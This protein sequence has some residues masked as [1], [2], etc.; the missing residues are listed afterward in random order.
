LAA[1]SKRKKKEKGPEAEAPVAPGGFAFW[2]RRLR[3]LALGTLVLAA[4]VWLSLPAVGRFLVVADKPAPAEVLVV[5]SGDRGERLE[6]AFRLYQEGLADRLLLSGG[7]L[8]ADLTEADLLRRHALMLGVPEYKIIMEPRA[9]NTY[10]NA[11]YSR[12]MMEYYGL[13]SAIVISSP[14]HM[15][16]VRALF[17]EVY[18]GSDIRLVYLP[19]EDSWFDPER[20]WESAA[21]RRVVL[22][23]YLRLT[24]L[25]LPEQW[26]AFLYRRGT[27]EPPMPERAGRDQPSLKERLDIS[28]HLRPPNLVV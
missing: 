18:R 26:R 16:R 27:G 20:W 23:E 3:N 8:Y 12:E 7:P 28:G 19:V 24:M 1:R 5:L 4:V 10:Q 2:R 17:D 21:G 9:T 14:Y 22:A 15:R 11:L 25:V 13:D 6:Y